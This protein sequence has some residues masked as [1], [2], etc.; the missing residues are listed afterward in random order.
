MFNYSGRTAL[1]TGASSGIGESFGQE[2]AAR[3]MN[4]ILVARSEDKLRLLAQELSQK[5]KIQV[6]VIAADLS[7]ER[8]VILVQ[9]AVRQN[10]L[11]VDLLINNA[12]SINYAPFEQIEPVK[13][14]QQV[15][16]NV[17]ATVDLTHAFVPQMLARQTGAIINVASTSAFYPTPYMAVYAATKAFVLSFSEALWVEYRDRGLRIL[18]LCPGPTKTSLLATS[19]IKPEQAALPRQV[20]L[21]GLR[22]LEQGRSYFI[23][24]VKNNLQSRLLPRVMPRPLVA[25]L[26]GKITRSGLNTD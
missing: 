16:L 10:G 1:I 21:A 22:A 26:I 15:M 9:E 19:L 18:A 5:Y 24:G 25:R 3:G 23:P 11:A 6:E 20:V 8:G 7:Q 13:D 14:H 12:G 2:L 4:V 17:A